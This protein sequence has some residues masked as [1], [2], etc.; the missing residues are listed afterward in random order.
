LFCR[1]KGKHRLA[2]KNIGDYGVNCVMKSFM[3]FVPYYSLLE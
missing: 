3:I 1:N 2:E